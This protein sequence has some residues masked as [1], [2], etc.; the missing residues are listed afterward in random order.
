[1]HPWSSPWLLLVLHTLPSLPSSLFVR[2]GTEVWAGGDIVIGCYTATQAQVP[3]PHPLGSTLSDLPKC[4]F[5]GQLPSL[6][7]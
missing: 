3:P 6:I 2:P 4:F 5:F 7:C 1:M